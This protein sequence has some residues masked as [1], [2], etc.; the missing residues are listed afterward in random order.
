MLSYVQIADRK[1]RPF[2]DIATNMH[3]FKASLDSKFTLA[4]TIK[5]QATSRAH[6]TNEPNW[7]A[8][9]DGSKPFK[10]W[11]ILLFPE[12]R[13][14]CTLHKQ[15]Y[16]DSKSQQGSSMRFPIYQYT[17]YIYQRLHFRSPYSKH[18]WCI[19]VYLTLLFWAARIVPRKLPWCGPGRRCG[20]SGGGKSQTGSPSKSLVCEAWQPPA[21][22]YKESQYHGEKRW[23]QPCLDV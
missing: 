18:T 3:G 6:Q 1:Y 12:K 4:Q 19:T 8:P 9:Q 13:L 11:N 15:I 5:P 7:F 20:F 2:R 23:R 10:C 17:V 21:D 14:E 22:V 16:I